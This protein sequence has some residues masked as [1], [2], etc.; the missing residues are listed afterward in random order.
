VKLSSLVDRILSVDRFTADLAITTA[1]EQ[2][3]NDLTNE[4]VIVNDENRLPRC[5]PAGFQ[6]VPS[7]NDRII[8]ARRDLCTLAYQHSVGI[9]I[10]LLLKDHNNDR[11]VGVCLI[12]RKLSYSECLFEDGEAVAKDLGEELSFQ[13]DSLCQFSVRRTIAL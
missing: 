5:T 8:F 7:R 11:E 1:L 3:P 10:G 13:R 6:T 2:A 4:G 9:T 12:P